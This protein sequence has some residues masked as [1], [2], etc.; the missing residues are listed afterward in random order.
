[1]E[2]SLWA[3]W[4]RGRNVQKLPQNL[5][6]RGGGTGTG[7]DARPQGCRASPLASSAAAGL[8]PFF[9]Y[10]I[11][12]EKAEAEAR[13]SLLEFHKG[14]SIRNILGSARQ[15]L[16]MALGETHPRHFSLLPNL[17]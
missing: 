11:Q 2:K 15:S 10:E 8:M 16:R 3:P 9:F 6:W 4:A 7:E 12:A 1:M 5:T 13:C 14:V 17:L